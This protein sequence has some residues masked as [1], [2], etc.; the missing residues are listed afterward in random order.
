MS[1]AA[2]QRA[3][4]K[5]STAQSSPMGTMTSGGGAGRRSERRRMTSISFNK[6]GLLLGRGCACS[7]WRPHLLYRLPEDIRLGRGVPGAERVPLFPGN[8]AMS[9]VGGRVEMDLAARV[10][11]EEADACVEL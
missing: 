2:T 7:T 1:A 5:R 11:G 10:P 4:P 3:S 9:V 6:G 8:P